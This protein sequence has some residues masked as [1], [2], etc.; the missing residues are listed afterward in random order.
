MHNIAAEIIIEAVEPLA[1]VV[2]WLHG[3]SADQHDL[4][5]L[6]QQLGR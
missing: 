2:I 3:L 6:A 5:P 4:I 1:G